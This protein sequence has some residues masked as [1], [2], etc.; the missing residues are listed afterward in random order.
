MT[1]RTTTLQLGPVINYISF[2]LDAEWEIASRT[3]NIERS[4]PRFEKYIA[5]TKACAVVLF[6]LQYRPMIPQLLESF[7][8]CCG[9]ADGVSSWILCCMVNSFDDTVRALGIRLLTAYM[10]GLTSASS[11]ASITDTFPIN[12]PDATSVPAKNSKMSTLAKSVTKLGTGFGVL[13]NASETSTKMNVK[14]VHKLLWH[15]LKCHR[16]RLG[17]TSHSALVHLLVDDGPVAENAARN[18]FL[19]TNIVI[20]D[21]TLQYGYIFNE[22]WAAPTAQVG[23][24]SSQRL[25]STYAIGTILRLLR[26]LRPEDIERWLFDLLALIRISPNSMTAFLPSSD[27]QPCLFLLVSEIV[28]E[29][30]RQHFKALE[31]DN[32]GIS[33]EHEMPVEVGTQEATNLK[34]D[35][36]DLAQDGM[37]VSSA[38][39]M[40]QT[41]SYDWESKETTA[42]VEGSNVARVGTRFDLCTKLY[43][44]LLGTCIRQGGDRAYQAVEQAASL[45]RVCVNGHEIFGIVL[46]HLLKELTEA[47]TVTI[48]APPM[49]P[50][51]SIER[52]RALKQS[53]LIVTNAILSNGTNEMDLTTAVKH[54]RCLRHLTAVTVAVVTASG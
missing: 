28:E 35:Q 34:T 13:G 15:L 25:R 42:Q 26:F 36:T 21:E 29:T 53:A 4:S 33:D 6:L 2:N 48:I 32:S 12:L 39:E 50:R 49:P 24:D 16:E 27:W 20:P 3:E 38:A 37:P 46:S 30:S 44:T 5:T 17:D 47:G 40:S 45:Q 10:G 51:S 19:A 1:P 31:L 9:N 11:K 23:I 52:N 14:V 7:E 22:R 41:R 8:I 18:E 54:W 43:A